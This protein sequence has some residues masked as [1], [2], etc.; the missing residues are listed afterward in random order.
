M[1]QCSVNYCSVTEGFLDKLREPH[2]RGRLSEMEDIL[3]GLGGKIISWIPTRE[4]REDC[5][6]NIWCKVS[7]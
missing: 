5:K 6:R 3:I 7:E 2:E 4:L 1:H